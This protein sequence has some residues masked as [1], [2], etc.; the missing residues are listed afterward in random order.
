MVA[1]N[2]QKEQLNRN[3]GGVDLRKREVEERLGGVDRGKIVVGC[4]I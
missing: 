3:R 2:T 4:N 1:Q